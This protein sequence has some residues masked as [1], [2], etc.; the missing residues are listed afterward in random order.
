MKNEM[1]ANNIITEQKKASHKHEDENEKFNHPSD[2]NWNRDLDT[3]KKY[4]YLSH[5]FFTAVSSKFLG[6]IREE[7][8]KFNHIRCKWSSIFI[9]QTQ[10][11]IMQ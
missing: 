8:E 3:Q 6:G 2:K 1:K 10:K 9:E 4:I 11:F 5:E 7:T